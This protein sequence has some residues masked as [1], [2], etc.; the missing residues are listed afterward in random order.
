MVADPGRIPASKLNSVSALTRFKSVA[1]TVS[2][3]MT[4]ASL[5]CQNFRLNVRISTLSDFPSVGLVVS[6]PA[7]LTSWTGCMRSWLCPMARTSIRLNSRMCSSNWYVWIK[8]RVHWY[9]AVS[10]FFRGQQET[11][12]S[13]DSLSCVPSPILLSWRSTVCVSVATTADIIAE[14]PYGFQA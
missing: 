14:G 7:M 10:C 5:A 13:R 9:D 11:Y 4:H 3:P 12:S 1:F 8:V 2:G 6:G